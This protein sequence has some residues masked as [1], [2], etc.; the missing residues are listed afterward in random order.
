MRDLQKLLNYLNDAKIVAF[1]RILSAPSATVFSN[2]LALYSKDLKLL[3][4][5]II[6]I[7]III[8][9]FNDYYY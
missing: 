7:I 1:S 6:I 4:L 8:K 2:N 5:L 3:L 9:R